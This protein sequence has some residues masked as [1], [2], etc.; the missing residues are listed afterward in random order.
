[1]FQNVLL[2]RSDALGTKTHKK[3]AMAE[4]ELGRLRGGADLSVS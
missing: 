1:M 4:G 2:E 3:V